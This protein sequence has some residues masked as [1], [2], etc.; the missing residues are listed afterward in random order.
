MESSGWKDGNEKGTNSRKGNQKELVD[1][2]RAWARKA[3]GLYNAKENVTFK[4]VKPSVRKGG[5]VERGKEA[6][7]KR[8]ELRG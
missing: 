4:E 6:N 1:W 8:H 3:G 7:R 2:M 5:A